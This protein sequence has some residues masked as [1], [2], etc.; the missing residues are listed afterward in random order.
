MMLVVRASKEECWTRNVHAFAT[1]YFIVFVFWSFLLCSKSKINNTNKISRVHV[2]IYNMHVNIF[3]GTCHVASALV[4]SVHCYC[5]WFSVPT[6]FLTRRV[7]TYICCM[8]LCV[9][10]CVCVLFLL[11]FFGWPVVH[12]GKVNATLTV[13]PNRSYVFQYSFIYSQNS[14][15]SSEQPLNQKD[16]TRRKCFYLEKIEKKQFMST[17]YTNIFVSAFIQQTR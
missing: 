8:P 17:L 2:C 11:L 16:K 13:I 3:V 4:H 7:F 15:I 5:C 9:W 10:V 6:F 12:V 1:V 14:S